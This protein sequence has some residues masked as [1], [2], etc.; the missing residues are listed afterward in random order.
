MPMKLRPTRV[1]IRPGVSVLS[2]LRHLNYRPWFALAEFVDNAIQSFNDWKAEIAKHDGSALTLTVDIDI[3]SSDAGRI[4]IRDN[5]GGI[6][7]K[8]YARAFRPAE[9]PADR[10]G[11]CE[12][13]MGMK[14]AACWF[15]PVWSVRTSALG[16]ETEKTIVFDISKIVRDEIEELEAQ[17]RTAKKGSHFTE[18]ALTELYNPPIGRTLGKMKEHLRDIYRIFIRDGVLTL[19]LN[20]EELSYQEPRILVAPHYR[21]QNGL[22]IT[23]RKDFDFDFGQGL[24]AHGFAAIRQ[25]AS[26][27]HA[28]FALFR[29]RRLIQGSGDEGYRPEIIFG[30]PNSFPYQRVF[31]EIHLEGFEVSHTKDGFKWDE[32]EEPFL[33]FLKDELSGSSLPLLQQAREHRVE[34]QRHEYKRGAEAATGRTSDTIRDHVPPVLSAIRKDTSAPSPPPKLSSATIAAHRVIDLEL[35]GQRWRI[36]LELTDDPAVGDWLEISDHVDHDESGSKPQSRRTVGLRLSL[37]HPFMQRFGGTDS[38]QIEP[39]LRVAAALG[40]AE[41]AARDSGVRK[42]GT[43]RRNVNELTQERPLPDLAQTEIAHEQW[44][45]QCGTHRDCLF[46]P[47]HSRP[48]ESRCHRRDAKPAGSLPA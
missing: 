30:K 23:W 17:V 8:D 21:K 16:E 18:I 20:G 45:E 38:E 27:T 43:I 31:G 9:L 24:R 28:G 48:M 33:Q 22:P 6:H 19:R 47:A 44:P 26:T 12:F 46:R 10:T 15:S 32:N 34:R 4:T 29:R 7:A 11:L 25:T 1:N 39:L 37:V 36:D 13:G 42:A 40:L 3:D 41:V 5:A 14:S 35:H 2:V